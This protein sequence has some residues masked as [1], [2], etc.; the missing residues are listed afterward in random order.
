MDDLRTK[1]VEAEVAALRSARSEDLLTRRKNESLG[2][3]EALKEH[4][5][6]KNGNGGSDER[7]Y[8]ALPVGGIFIRSDTNGLQIHQ[9]HTDKL[10]REA[11]TAAK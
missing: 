8:C 6:G 1:V 7:L 11:H 9:A 2:I 5:K 4:N 3:T 10:L